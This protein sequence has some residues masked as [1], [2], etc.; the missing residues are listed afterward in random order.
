MAADTRPQ[1]RWLDTGPNASKR[2]SPAG[3]YME[4]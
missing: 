3:E 2:H 4:V 1:A